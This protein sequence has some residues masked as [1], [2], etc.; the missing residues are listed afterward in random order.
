MQ[1]M[2]ASTIPWCRSLLVWVLGKMHRSVKKTFQTTKKSHTKKTTTGW[3]HESAGGAGCAGHAD[4][5]AKGW[6][7]PYVSA[8][9]SGGHDAQ[10]LPKG[11]QAQAWGRHCCCE[12]VLEGLLGQAPDQSLGSEPPLPGQQRSGRSGNHNPLHYALGCRALHQEA[13][14]LL[15]ILDLYAGTGWGEGF[16][17]FL[18]CFFIFILF[19]D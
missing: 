11:V 17:L 12:R 16:C 10:G 2:M 3:S 13:E 18:F 19:S 15:H 1:W 6:G 5:G 7:D 4:P 9:H 14:L 8:L